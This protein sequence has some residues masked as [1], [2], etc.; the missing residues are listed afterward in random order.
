MTAKLPK[1]ASAFIEGPAV[2]MVPPDLALGSAGLYG[3][4]SGNRR[5]GRKPGSGTSHQ[6]T[7]AQASRWMQPIRRIG[8]SSTKPADLLT[9]MGTASESLSDRRKALSESSALTSTSALTHK[10]IRPGSDPHR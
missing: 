9:G 7:L 10:A 3:H 1:P 5:R 4:G 2:E 6:S 8:L